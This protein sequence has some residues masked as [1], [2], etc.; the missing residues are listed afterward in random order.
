[1]IEQNTAGRPAGAS[2]GIP[3]TAMAAARSC[4]A[5]K[6]PSTGTIWAVC[7]FTLL[8]GRIDAATVDFRRDVL[9]ILSDACFQCHG[10]DEKARKAKLRLDQREGIFRTR[11]DVT[12]VRPGKPAESELVA[13]TSSK[14][15]DEVMP[16][17]DAKRQLT[18]AEIEVLRRWVAEGAPWEGHW[19]FAPMARATPPP[20]EIKSTHPIDAWVRARLEA[21]KL[22]PA[23]EADRARLLRRVTLDLTGLTPTTAELTAFEADLA[24]DAYENVVDRLLASPRF[25]ERMA[26]DWLDVARYAD[27]HGYQMDRP[28]AMWAWRDWVIS[29]FNQNLP[30]DQFVTWQL[31]GDLLPGATKTQRLATAFNRLHNQNEE[32]GIVE[33]EYRVAYVAD[34]VTTFGTAFLGLTLEC[35]RC[36]DHKYDPITQREFYGLSSFFQNID[37]A[38]QISYVGFADAMPVPTLLLTTDEQDRELAALQARA[39]EAQAALERARTEADGAAFNHWLAHD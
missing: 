2:R 19:A 21:E 30:Y 25:G 16:P 29:A 35:A 17:P 6:S 28:R 8:L 4:C 13:R 5:A 27:T 33:E 12:V 20:T 7:A 15:D 18:R 24:A 22:L 1:M 26:T 37:E 11:E 31:A 34:R 36:H 10:P 9:P 38:G 23:P 14:D 3:R 32:G 39:A